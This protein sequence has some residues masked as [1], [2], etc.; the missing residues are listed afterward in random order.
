MPVN[1]AG[2]VGKAT[3][4]YETVFTETELRE[5]AIAFDRVDRRSFIVPNLNEIRF[6]LITLTDRELHGGVI[7]ALGVDSPQWDFFNRGLYLFTVQRVQPTGQIMRSQRGNV[8]STQ[9]L[10]YY[11]FR[12]LGPTEAPTSCYIVLK[13]RYVFG[14]V[15]RARSAVPA[16]GFRV[17][18]LYVR[19]KGYQFR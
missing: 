15:L 1:K 16:T 17:V 19:T 6:D 12:G 14:L 8:Q 3:D 5:R 18:N 2:T 13:Q 4:I 11:T 10:Q 7:T 9:E